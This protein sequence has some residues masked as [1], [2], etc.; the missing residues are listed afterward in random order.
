ML[1]VRADL[2]LSDCTKP[3]ISS[4]Y[5]PVLSHKYYSKGSPGKLKY[6]L[7]L[8]IRLFTVTDLMS[9]DLA[10]L[11]HS[12]DFGP[13]GCT[14]VAQECRRQALVPVLVM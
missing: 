10:P 13:T 4:S 12:V 5:Q 3:Q 8:L 6:F 1:V 9:E 14:L 11:P 7:P 2:S